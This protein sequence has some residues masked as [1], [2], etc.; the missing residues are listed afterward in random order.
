MPPLRPASRRLRR[1]ALIAGLVVAALAFSGCSATTT[2]PAATGAADA[3]TITVTHARGESEVPAQAKRV[4]VLEPVALDASVALGVIPVGA[5]VLN[6]AAGIPAY[7]GKAAS[8]IQSVG[9]VTEPNVEKIAALK[10]DL[11][12]GTES[13]HSALYDQLSSVA[14][15]VFLASQADPWKDNVKL[16][17]K[18]L[19]LADQA[20]TLLAGY[21]ARCDEVKAEF[22]V[23]GKTAQLIR[24]RDGLLTVY[25]PESFAGS[26][27]ECVGFTTPARDWQNSISV[28]LS[29]EKVLEASADLVV[30]TTTNVDDPTTMPEAITANP[31][32]FPDV[33]LV[34]QSYWITG[35]GPMGGLKVL[36]DIESIL[37]DAQ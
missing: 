15:T 4:V 23:E 8:G 16:V 18:A 37:R 35:V 24:P 32:S 12:I 26:T 10:P 20:D 1:P 25:G 27:L 9:T 28:D 17:G 21:D 29:P 2:T 31:S 3:G 19:G 30:V 5:A 34:D 22:A 11:I 13:R 33:H 14:P 36:D 6:E 7:L